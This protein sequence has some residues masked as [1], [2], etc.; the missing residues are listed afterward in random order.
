MAQLTEILEIER[1]R[2]L[3]TQAGVIYLYQEGSFLRA[4]EWSAWLCVRYIHVFKATHRRIKDP[5]QTMAFIG[6]PITSLAKFTPEGYEVHESD[7]R[8]EM[9]L[10]SQML[11]ADLSSMPTDFQAWKNSLPLEKAKKEE[12]K[13]PDET[14]DE[15]NPKGGCLL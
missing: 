14:F 5:E 7:K 3:Q 4:Y 13:E 11:P 1:K 12:R 8:A 15:R 10:P 6:F 2:D 9:I